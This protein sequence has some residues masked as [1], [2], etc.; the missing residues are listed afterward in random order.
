MSLPDPVTRSSR[1]DGPTHPSA[2]SDRVGAR[3]LWTVAL[4]CHLLAVAILAAMAA[5]AG[6]HPR[7][8]CEWGCTAGDS[9]FLT[10][11]VLG[12]GVIV[13]YLITTAMIIRDLRLR[14]SRTRSQRRRSTHESKWRWA[15]RATLYSA[16]GMAGTVAALTAYRLVATR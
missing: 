6:S 13:S 12:P 9:V 3:V 14:R 7:P 8:G 16:C 10:L 15:G 11:F 2:A 5:W 4:A 1:T